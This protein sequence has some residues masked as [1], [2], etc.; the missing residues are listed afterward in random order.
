MNRYVLTSLVIV[1]IMSNF[2][3]AQVYKCTDSK[4]KIT[5]QEKTCN[6]NSE[7]RAIK[8]REG[9]SKEKIEEAIEKASFIKKRAEAEKAEKAKEAE[10]KYLK[11]SSVKEK[12]KNKKESICK[13]YIARYEAEKEKVIS[14]CKRRREVYCKETPIKILK[15][16][17]HIW[18]RTASDNEIKGYKRPIIFDYVQTLKNHKCKF[19]E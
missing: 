14:D 13:E 19:K 17:R 3:H 18:M 4:G 15:I 1:F 7:Q 12:E 8:I 2:S 10:N 16:Q 9:P 6:V 11:Q 5:Y